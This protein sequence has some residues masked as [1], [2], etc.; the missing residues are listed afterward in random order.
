MGDDGR[1]GVR[2]ITV[3]IEATVTIEVPDHWVQVGQLANEV[4][5]EEDALGAIQDGALVVTSLESWSFA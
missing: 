1:G 3:T 5:I 4:S 2:T